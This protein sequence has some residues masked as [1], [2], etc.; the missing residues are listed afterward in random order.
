[1]S[2]EQHHPVFFD[3]RGVRAPTISGLLMGLVVLALAGVG[4]LL[5]GL[6]VTAV[7]PEAPHPALEAA[8]S[9]VRPLETTAP[10]TSGP[11]IDPARNRQLPADAVA[12]RRWAFL[13]NDIDALASLRRHAHKLDAVVA[14]LFIL[15]R[16]D[17]GRVAVR[18]L[19]EAD[20]ALGWLDARAPDLPVFANV[21]SRLTGGETLRAVA[22][23]ASRARLVRELTDVVAAGGFAGLVLELHDLATAQSRVMATLLSELEGPL[24]AAGARLIVAASVGDA[25]HRLQAIAP[26]VD[27]V[28]LH[29][30]GGYP[31]WNAMAPPAAQAWFEDRLAAALAAVPRDKLVVS[32]GSY[33]VDPRHDDY[34]RVVSVQ[35]GWDLARAWSGAIRLDRD[36]LNSYLAFRPGSG[37]WT[38]P[39]PPTRPAPR[40]RRA[41]TAWRCGGSAPRTRASGRFSGAGACRRSPRS[42]RCGRCPAGTAAWP[43]PAAR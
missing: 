16:G 28:V 23:P 43:S 10:P 30:H 22:H 15:G 38:P 36:A 39:R 3:P 21:T 7:M 11:A 40:W 9:L 2:S 14:D 12:T 1:M 27:A 8:A 34:R 31:A 33:G 20:R 32:I 24:T 42:T 6:Y 29:A 4:A 35:R 18:P 41:C 17:D 25:P 5:V 19:A 13:P 26:L 37:C